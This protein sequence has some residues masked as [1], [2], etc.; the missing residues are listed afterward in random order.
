MTKR[1]MMDRHYSEV[2]MRT[3]ELFLKDGIAEGSIT[4]NGDEIS[5]DTYRAKEANKYYYAATWNAARKCW[6]IR[7]DLKFAEL[8]FRD[9]L[10]VS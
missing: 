4:L 1:E 9:G 8:I 5:G 2:Q 6:T 10:A 7:K 3:A